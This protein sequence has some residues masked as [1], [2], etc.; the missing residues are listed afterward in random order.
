MPAPFPENEDARLKA[1]ADYEIL[2]TQPETA[3]DD[4]T[5]I[6]STVCETPT[7]LMTLL[8]EHRQWFKSKIG[9]DLQETPREQAFCA[10][11]IL[12]PCPMTVADASQDA[13]FADNPLVTSGPKI[14]FYAGVPLVNTG[15]HALGSLCVIDTI[16]RVLSD[17]QIKVLEALGRQ[18]INILELRRVSAQ[19]AA[20]AS[21]INT[22]HGLLP[23]CGFCK[24]IRDDSGYWVKVE[25]YIRAHSDAN[26]SH[27]ICRACSEKHYPELF[28]KVKNEGEPAVSP[29][30]NFDQPCS[31]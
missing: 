22:L 15:G 18:M 16:P 21:R 3:Y 13:R 4:I 9:L 12:H 24:G 8:D 2:D 1:L 19:L 31:T 6:A 26:F 20:E 30:A 29:N 5:F 11:T 10:H 28:A 17:T 14:R 23:I 25:D 7:S 27:G